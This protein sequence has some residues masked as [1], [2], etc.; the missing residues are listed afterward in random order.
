[1]KISLYTITLS[2]GYYGGPVVPLLEIFPKAKAWGYDG[3]E[4]EGKRPHGSPLDLDAA[5]RKQI[6]KAAEDYGLE[7]S[8]VAAYNDY[9]SPIEEHRENE[10][11][12]TREQIRLAA[13]L[14]AP[15]VRVFAVW[16]GVTLRDGC[17]TYDVARYNID[18]RYPGTT[19]L[20]RW[21]YVR[22]CLAEAARMA[23]AEGV[24]LAL[25]NHEPIITH[26]QH[27]LDFIAEVNSPA[28]KACL[29]SPLMK[30][31]TP[32][33]YHEAIEATGELLVHTHFGGRFERQEDGTVTRLHDKAHPDRAD[34]LAFLRAAKS[35]VNYQGH[36]G[37]ELCSPVLIGH[38]HAGLEYALEQASLA[39]EYM[40]GIVNSL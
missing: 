26:Y 22:D 17:I 25:Q 1:M 33:Y 9:S 15:V 29:D 34:D 27:M 13:E 38:R 7:I 23:E 12:M 35:I 21:C 3:I 24:T 30:S 36:I 37:Y 14:E 40:R 16:S 19:A 11:L 18:H 10:L 4:L 8:C 6:R 5:A 28:L 32:E 39:C 2:G 20:E 31:H